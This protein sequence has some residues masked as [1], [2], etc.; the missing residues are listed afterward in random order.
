MICGL[1]AQPYDVSHV[2][3]R[4]SI[5]CLAC[6]AQKRC[7][8]PKHFVSYAVYDIVVGIVIVFTIVVSMFIF[9]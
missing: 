4:K 5:S 2:H 9:L 8:C 6:L 7:I 1:V 3:G